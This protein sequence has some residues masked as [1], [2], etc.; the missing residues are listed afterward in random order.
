MHDNHYDRELADKL[1]FKLAL[2]TMGLASVA[3]IFCLQFISVN[4]GFHGT[5]IPSSCP[6]DADIVVIPKSGMCGWDSEK[7]EL[8]WYNI[9]EFPKLKDD[10]GMIRKITF[11]RTATCIK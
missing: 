8:Y 4:H 7:C 5:S 10:A 6:K 9:E 3:A 1:Q 11:F 2:S